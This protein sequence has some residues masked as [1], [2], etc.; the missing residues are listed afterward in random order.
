MIT[1]KVSAI[2]ATRYTQ[3]FDVGEFKP[4][5]TFRLTSTN[6]I[7]IESVKDSDDTTYYEVPYLAQEMVYIKSPNEAYN[8]PM[9]AT[10]NSPKYILKLQ[11]TNK[12][13]TTRLVDEQTIEGLMRYLG[14]IP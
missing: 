4:N 11:Q 10:A 12:R 8:E 5:P 9:L 1:K 13:F 6:F 3:T 2:S 14:Y 7:K